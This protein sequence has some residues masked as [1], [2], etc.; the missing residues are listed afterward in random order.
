MGGM[1]TGRLWVDGLMAIIWGWLIDRF[2]R[3]KIIT[4]GSIFVGIF[5]TIN[6]FAPVGGGTPNYWFWLINRICIGFFMSQGGP[7]IYSLGNDFLDKEEKSRFFGLLLITFVIF[8]YVGMFVSAILF[9]IGFWQVFLLISAGSYFLTAIVISKFIKEPKRGIREPKLSQILSTTDARYE[10]KLNRHT[11]KS[12]TFSKSNI[13][14]LVEGFSTNLIFGI[15]DLILLPFMQSAPHNIAPSTTAIFQILFSIPGSIIG[16]IFLAKLSDRIGKK[17]L[18]NRAILVLVSISTAIFTFLIVFSMPWPSLTPEEGASITMIIQYPIFFFFGSMFFA[19]SAII[20]LY[21]LNQGPIIQELN[22]PESQ[23]TIR[24]WNQFIEVVSYGSGPLVGGI[25]LQFVGQNYQS[26]I[27]FVVLFTIPGILLWVIVY[28]TI[29][30]DYKRVQDLLSLRA[31][32]IK[33]KYQS[34]V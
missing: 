8:Q 15:I 34:K 16:F 22:L 10:Y 33:E 31:V 12:T 17:S 5:I 28:F 32:E 19:N 30:A 20:G 18:K 26:T 25:L 9:E 3:K 7:A 29:E 4:R 27:Q 13:L 1:I 21:A 11:L 2:Q 23:G 14:V 6:I 24:G